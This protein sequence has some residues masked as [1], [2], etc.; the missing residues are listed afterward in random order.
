MLTTKGTYEKY[1]TKSEKV[2]VLDYKKK[3]IDNP[4]Y[5]GYKGS[6]ANPNYKGSNYDPNYT[7]S[8]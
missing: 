3:K 8:T 4:N 5:K 2:I 6:K 1:K 7:K